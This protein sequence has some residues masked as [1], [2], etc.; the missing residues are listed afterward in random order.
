MNKL[1][2]KPQ[3]NKATL[4]Y[5]DDKV[6]LD[7]DGTIAAIELSYQGNVKIYPRLSSGWQMVNKNNKIIIFGITKKPLK[8]LN[9]FVL[10]NYQGG[11]RPKNCRIT[12]WNLEQINVSIKTENIHQWNLIT[13]NWDDLTLKYV[14]LKKGTS[15]RGGGGSRGGGY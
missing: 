13:N 6:T 5:G 15:T 11:F 3:L 4:T 9:E 2:E 10:L 12:G 7:V 8:K 1:K 14:E